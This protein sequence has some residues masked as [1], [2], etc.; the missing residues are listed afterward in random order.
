M[1]SGAIKS[2]REKE[3][4]SQK[5]LAELLSI[6]QSTVGMWESGKREP[7]FAMIKKLSE[8][9]HVSAGELIGCCD[10]ETQKAEERLTAEAKTEAVPMKVGLSKNII[11]YIMEDPSME[12]QIQEGDNLTF[13][14][15]SS[16]IT[17][18]IVL[19]ELKQKEKRVVRKFIKHQNGLSLT[20]YHPAYRPVFFDLEEA[21]SGEIS[22][23]GILKTLNRDFIL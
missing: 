16:A 2:I 14:K 13:E 11:T 9:F 3:G 15:S 6:A 21:E 10:S 22:I 8:L 5:K 4:L 7:E 18:Q 1:F 23:I 19:A 17:G 20:A 12:P